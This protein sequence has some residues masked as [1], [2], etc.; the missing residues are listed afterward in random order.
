MS[1]D[2]VNPVKSPDA[3]AGRPDL[4]TLGAILVSFVLMG[5]NGFMKLASYQIEIDIFTA[6]GLEPAGRYLVGVAEIVAVI[7]LLIPRT[8]FLGAV[9]T[10]GVMV[11]AI[12][13]HPSGKIGLGGI[14]MALLVSAA[15]IWIGWQHRDQA[16]W[17]GRWARGNAEA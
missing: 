8:R 14:W 16:P 2:H 10:M 3:G 11:G 6:L 4:L 13:S 15:A 12:G 1:S 17:I 5:W 7:L 9:L